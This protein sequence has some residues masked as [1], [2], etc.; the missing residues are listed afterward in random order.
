MLLNRDDK[1]AADRGARLVACKKQTTPT[2]QLICLRA[3]LHPY[4][5]F[6]SS[7]SVL[8]CLSP[9]SSYFL[10]TA[11]ELEPPFFIVS[12]FSVKDLPERVKLRS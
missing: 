10:A 2:W 8:N 1:S 11:L 3:A 6:R 4:K 9:F 5:H 7:A 12:T